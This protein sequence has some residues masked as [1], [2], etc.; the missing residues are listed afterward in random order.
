M[1]PADPVTKFTVELRQLAYCTTTDMFDEYLHIGIQLGGSVAKFCECVV[2]AFDT[3]YLCKS[4]ATDWQFLMDM[5]ERKHV[6]L[7][8]LGSIYCMHWEWENC[9]T[10]WRGQFT[11]GYKCTHSTMIL[12]VIVDYRLWIW[13]AH[14]G[15]AR[16]N[17]DINVLN[18]SSLFTEQCSGSGP[19]LEFTANERHHHMGYYLTNGIYPRWPIF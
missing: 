3:T 10:P 5:H 4:N 13:H 7:G 6:F 2:E 15:V 16:S 9:L 11:S 12:E 17:D 18:T 14:L 8:M 19:V 1:R